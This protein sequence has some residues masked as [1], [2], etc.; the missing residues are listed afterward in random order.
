M[1]SSVPTP[2]PSGAA[3][4]PLFTARQLAHALGITKRAALYQLQRLPVRGSLPGNGG[5]ADAWALDDLPF[6]LRQRLDAEAAK[7]G[8]RAAAHLLARKEA[9]W[10]PKVP[11]AEIA[12][13]TLEAA[14][15]LQEA[16]RPVLERIN[17]LS[18]S[19]AELCAQGVREY[20]R[21]FG[22]AISARHWRRLL[23]RVLARAGTDDTWTRTEL[24]L[25]DRL[26]R[27]AP[28]ASGASPLEA[29][30]VGAPLQRAIE[31]F[32]D[33]SHPTEEERGYLWLRAFELLEELAGQ[34]GFTERRTKRL[35]AAF[36]AERA[37]WLAAAD[38]E[39][40]FAAIRRTFERKL[41][42]WRASNRAATALLDGRRERS[43]RFRAPKLSDEDRD[44][45]VGHAV[46]KCGG[47]ISQ[48]WREL[49]E[50]DELSDDL[51]AYYR[52]ER[53]RRKSE[54][55][56]RI[57]K[58]CEAEV[59]AMHNIHRG[60]R[61][62]RLLGAYIDRDWSGVASMD[63]FC[64]DDITLPVYFHEQDAHGQLQLMRGQFLALID[65]RTTR[66]LSFALLSSK[67][68]NSRAIRTLIVRACD[69]HGL[70]RRGFLFEGGLWEN[71]R[72]LKG[73]RKE[74]L[75]SW[76]E[77]E[78]G[79]RQFGLEFRHSRLPR[80][81]PVERVARAIQDLME[82]EPGYTGRDE[83]HDKFERFAQLK[84]DVEAGRLEAREHL[85]SVE[86]WAERLVEICERYN[87]E[88]Q[89]GKMTDGLS[90]DA[91]FA[92]FARADDPPIKLDATCRYLL[93]HHRKP[94]RVSRNGI[95]VPPS[96]GGA[97]YR[98]ADTGPL[99]GREVLAWYN[100]ETPELLTIT[101]LQRR[102]PVCIPRAEA[103]PAMDATPEQLRA[104]QSQVSAHNA[105]ASVR[106][107]VLRSKFAAPT[108]TN[109][110]DRSTVELGQ[111]IE[112][113]ARAVQAEQRTTAAR[114]TRAA[115][116][117]HA[118]GITPA[119][120]RDDDAAASASSRLEKLLAAPEEI[121]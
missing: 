71:S 78:L 38:V 31:G 29:A 43:G 48:A 89:D 96:W 4:P 101:D 47:R 102:N 64:A 66:I 112:A 30:D 36:L 55:P 76:G 57:R 15:R 68:Y 95:R 104:A 37:P 27:R 50:A 81:K 73:D 28:V 120:L 33:P 22:L 121:L 97:V 67:S 118:L 14:R 70:P 115:R 98:S 103:I 40:R 80:S 84:L 2:T 62:H 41:A 109:L 79:L 24:F 16:L 83:V 49:C 85:Y 110:T 111:R 19:E 6:A 3:A 105:H 100:P 82:A 114:R 35:L 25:P 113:Q 23:A 52:T 45:I 90:P 60:P 108:R 42:L 39:D 54:V 12:A 34:R 17:D 65:L 94:V 87:A 75:F 72:L 1:A 61:T 53:R 13:D 92:A 63:W 86:Q 69:E 9:P 11:L 7:H 44:K 93:A 77:V 51:I 32:T 106:Y 5:P 107:R 117:A 88:P 59:K 99:V 91:A 58:A 46:L 18:I 8:F 56:A 10:Q 26:A 74:N 21:V 116:S 119:A 20:A